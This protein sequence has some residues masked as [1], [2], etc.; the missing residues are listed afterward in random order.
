MRQTLATLVEPAGNSLAMWV[1]DLGPSSACFCCG[2]P[3][4]PSIEGQPTGQLSLSLSCPLCGAG[5][6]WVETLGANSLASELATV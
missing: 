1:K 6:D 4:F 3:L 2:A 5:V